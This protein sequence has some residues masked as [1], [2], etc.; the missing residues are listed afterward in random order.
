MKQVGIITMEKADN[1]PKNS[2]GSSRIRARWLLPYWPEAEEYKM[3]EEYEVTIFQ[4]VYWDKMLEEYKGIKILDLCDPDWLEGRPVFQ[5]VDLCD[6]VVTSSQPLADYILKL[7][8]EQKVVCIPD[9]ILLTEHKPREIKHEKRAEKIVWFGYSHNVHY[10]QKT[11]EELIQYGLKLVVISNEAYYPPSVYNNLQIENIPY[12]YDTV[13][14]EIKKCDLALMPD[15]TT[16]DLKGKFK[17]N[18]KTLTCWA[19]GVP[20]VKEPKDLAKLIGGEARQK[21]ADKRL[22]EIK[23]KWDVKYSVEEYRRLIEE[24]KQNKKLST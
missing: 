19:L 1:R 11:F 15:T 22:Q 17:S 4:K 7:R 16:D 8:P 9:R 24:L 13:H 6:A 21:E 12:N 2:V 23:D 18:N 3:G 10:L 20:V 14:E 5:Y